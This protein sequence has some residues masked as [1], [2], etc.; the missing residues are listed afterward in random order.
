[1][2]VETKTLSKEISDIAAYVTEKPE[3]KIPYFAL[4]LREYRNKT[5]KTR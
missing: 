1:M 2:S 5:I 4:R 3:N